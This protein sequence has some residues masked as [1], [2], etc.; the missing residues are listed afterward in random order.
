MAWIVRR[1]VLRLSMFAVRLYCCVLCLWTRLCLIEVLGMYG[2]LRRV[3]CGEDGFVA[4]LF[5]SLLC[6][7]GR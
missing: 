4:W 5:C 2:F 6:D 3:K 1:G 7:L